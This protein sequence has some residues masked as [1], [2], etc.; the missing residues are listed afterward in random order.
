M[1][2]CGI[3]VVKLAILMMAFEQNTLPSSPHTMVYV[4]TVEGFSGRVSTHRILFRESTLCTTWREH[5]FALSHVLALGLETTTLSFL[6]DVRQTAD[7]KRREIMLSYKRGHGYIKMQR[8]FGPESTAFKYRNHVNKYGACETASASTQL[9]ALYVL[10][11]F[12]AL[13]DE[14]GRPENVLSDVMTLSGPMKT[15]PQD[16]ES[17]VA[18][19]CVIF[20]GAFPFPAL[21]SFN[22]P[23]DRAFHRA[24]RTSN[25]TLR[26]CHQCLLQHHVLAV[27]NFTW[28]INSNS[29]LAKA[30]PARFPAA[31]LPDFSHVAN[32]P[33]FS[34]EYPLSPPPLHSGAAPLHTHLA[35]PSSA[36]KKTALLTALPT[37]PAAAGACVFT[38]PAAQQPCD[39]LDVLAR[40]RPARDGVSLDAWLTHHRPAKT[41][42]I[43][44]TSKPIPW[45]QPACTITPVCR[46]TNRRTCFGHVPQLKT[47]RYVA[48]ERAGKTRDG[49]TFLLCTTCNHVSLGAHKLPRR[50]LVMNHR[51]YYIIA[52]LSCRSTDTEDTGLGAWK[53]CRWN[54][55]RAPSLR[56]EREEPARTIDSSPTGILS[57]VRLLASHQGEPVSNPVGIASGISEVGDR[58]GRCRGS[59]G[60]LL[61]SPFPLPLNSGAAPYSPHFTLIGSQTLLLRAAPKSQLKHH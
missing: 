20:L 14:S 1:N 57:A 35:S 50:W 28:G 41:A 48:R 27:V 6:S 3:H 56:R 30:N 33:G 4:P 8:G 18:N 25:T 31:S 17:S 38:Q 37:K 47:G 44:R 21:L 53:G 29:P 34:R 40:R 52:S 12:R 7:A 16:G 55:L 36:L 9:R 13:S 46:P 10:L 61:G 51:R 49:V 54:R 22:R 43:P 42:E 15:R 60:F 32:K 2:C 24:G 39:T 58:A 26:P 45:E 19:T 23:S 5:C 11:L 59:A